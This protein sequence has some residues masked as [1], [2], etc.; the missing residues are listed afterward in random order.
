MDDYFLWIRQESE[1]LKK[2]LHQWLDD[3]FCPEPAND[4]IS[5]RCSKVY[6]YCLLEKQLDMGEILLQMIRELETFSF[7]K[8]FHG[9]FTSAN[10]AVDIITKKIH[11]ME[12]GK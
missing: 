10:A 3:E 9:A 4:E 5:R 8:S 1:W 7:K 11:S 2:S 6:Y 12:E